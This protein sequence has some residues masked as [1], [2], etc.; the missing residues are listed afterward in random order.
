MDILLLGPLLLAGGL[1]AL[2]G[3]FDFGG[4]DS[5]DDTGESPAPDPDPAPTHPHGGSGDDSLAADHGLLSGWG[6]DDHLTL[7]GTARGYGNQGDDTLVAQDYSSA[8]GGLGDDDLI[9]SS[10]TSGWGGAG[11]DLLTHA[12]GEDQSFG[13]SLHGDEGNDTLL[14]TTADTTLEGGAG[15]DLLVIEHA[16][17]TN[18]DGL[19]IDMAEGNDTLFLDPQALFPTV[20][21]GSTTPVVLHD[22]A[23]GDRIVFGDDASSD[24]TGMNWVQNQDGSFT[25]HRLVDETNTATNLTV[26]TTDGQE[27]INFE[28]A[29][30]WQY[31][32]VSVAAWTSAKLEDLRG[33]SASDSATEVQFQHVGT[34]EDDT[35]TSS[36]PYDYASLHGLAGDDTIDVEA[37][38]AYGGS[39]DDIL[40]EH[41]DG[42]QF[43]GYGGTGSDT[44]SGFHYN[45][46]QDGNDVITVTD[47]SPSGSSTHIGEAY[48]GDGD[49]TIYSSGRWDNHG[50]DMLAGDAGNDA[51]HAYIDD[52][53]DAGSGADTVILTHYYEADATRVDESQVVLGAGADN[54]LLDVN[55]TAAAASYTSTSGTTI[56][57][58]NQVEGD[59]LGIILPSADLANVGINVV[60]GPAGAY[61]D[62][63]LTIANTGAIPLTETFRLTGVT[64][65]SAADIQ[66][67]ENEAA[68]QAGTAYGHA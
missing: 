54:L 65:F 60:Q 19:H 34:Q 7:T 51:I 31:V 16:D 10:G 62:V 23:P 33:F 22:F 68:A 37:G 12:P 20:A 1:I 67:F 41:I 26:F 43:S 13:R 64:N 59:H 66:L 27:P 4:N 11:E 8:D 9:L 6:G 63:V 50:S 52:N 28:V 36:H 38:D 46:G 57:D 29:H 3:G 39:G 47:V 17:Q 25:L 48:G 40:V 44:L 21:A 56:S 14:G 45:Y 42:W 53:V 35:L 5:S 24:Y 2:L 55:L 61:C 58:F 30:D 18:P 32:G 49:D 15:N